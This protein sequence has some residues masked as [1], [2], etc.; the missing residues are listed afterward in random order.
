MWGRPVLDVVILGGGPGGY[1][2][3]GRLRA[4]GKTVTIVER[5]EF[6]GVCL[7]EGCIPSKCLLNSAKL[8]AHARESAKFGVTVE[9]AKFDLGVAVGWK[10]EVVGRLKGSLSALMQRLGVEIV[11]GEAAL[12][13]DH[14]V[15]AGDRTLEAADVVIATG[16]RFAPL[17]VPGVDGPNVI[18]SREMLEL[19]ALPRRIAIVGAGAVGLE[20]ASFFS[21]V[22]VE[23][24][25]VEMLTEIAPFMDGSLA[26]AMRRAMKQVTFHLGSKVEA[27]EPGG[28]VCSREGVRERVES[29]TV[30]VCTG[31]KP[32]VE[33]LGLELAGVDVERAG[34]RVDARCRTNLPHVWA[35]GDVNGV[36]LFAHSAARMGEVAAEAI[37]HGG[38]ASRRG[39][40]ERFRGHAIPWA[41]FGIPEAAGCGLTEDE[42][43]RQGIAVRTAMVPMRTSGR[44]L[45]EHGDAPGMAKAV[46]AKDDGRVLGVHLLGDGC[47]EMIWGVAALLEMELRAKDV[48]EIV[49]PHPTVSEV[50]RDAI[51][52]AS[53]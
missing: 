26:S 39:A 29:D 20:A 14:V 18:W 17:P 52:A 43:K 46:V 22:G 21:A 3:A 9:G 24:H 27:I 47:S 36:S 16:S 48:R 42:A 23:V 33:G 32:N 7:N 5:G 45:A 28:V 41:L 51:A 35:V 53:A 38:E 6:G 1:T 50:V 15:R 34:I 19:A 4:L 30:L 11:A 40:G 2:A 49:F 31:R 10:R 44:F 25:V 13:S 8:Y 12:V 37:V